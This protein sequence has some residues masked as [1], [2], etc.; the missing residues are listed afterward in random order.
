M[1]QLLNTSNYTQCNSVH[2]SYSLIYPKTM[3]TTSAT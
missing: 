2:T 1:Q 3:F